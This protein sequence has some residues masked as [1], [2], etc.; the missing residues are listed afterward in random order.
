[1]NFYRGTLYNATVPYKIAT[2]N[3]NKP[4]IE[5]GGTSVLENRR[6]RDTTGSFSNNNSSY[7]PIRGRIKLVS[8]GPHS[9]CLSANINA[10]VLPERGTILHLN[11]SG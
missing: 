9:S 1:M 3:F 2:Y 8:A 6:V 5:G 11:G 4:K 7:V 10:F